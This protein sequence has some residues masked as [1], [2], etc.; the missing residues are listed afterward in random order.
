MT[1][2]SISAASQRLNLICG[3]PCVSDL[4]VASLS[5]DTKPRIPCCCDQGVP[6]KAS[7]MPRQASIQIDVI[8]LTE[9]DFKRPWRMHCESTPHEHNH[10]HRRKQLS[11]D[12]CP[13]EERLQLLRPAQP[14]LLPWPAT[15]HNS[16]TQ[17][18]QPVGPVHRPCQH[19]ACFVP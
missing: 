13:A 17:T 8:E 7:K 10:A 3:L 2:S 1:P 12:S 4:P 19:P 16:E 15:G 6:M 14:R 5:P 9:P 18:Q 11:P